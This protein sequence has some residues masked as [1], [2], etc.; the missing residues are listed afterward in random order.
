M[1]PMNRSGLPLAR[2]LAAGAATAAA[3]ASCALPAVAHAESASRTLVPPPSRDEDRPDHLT[4]TVRDAGAGRDGTYHLSCHP[5]S[6]DHP[7]VAGACAALDRGTHWGRE[8]F[9]PVPDGSMCTMQYG[10]PATAHVTGTWAGRPVDA[11]YSRGDGCEIAR[12]DRMVPLLPDL[13]PQGR[14]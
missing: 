3:V 1:S 2:L 6:G 7:D 5:G 10:G 14:S 13:R 4:V 12:W 11:S 8:T 9:A